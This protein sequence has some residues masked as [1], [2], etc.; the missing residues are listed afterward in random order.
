VPLQLCHDLSH[1]VVALGLSFAEV[2]RLLWGRGKMRQVGRVLIYD[3]S[4]PKLW[5]GKGA[6]TS[7]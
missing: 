2:F 3:L 5:E 6:R 4:S 7:P 1:A